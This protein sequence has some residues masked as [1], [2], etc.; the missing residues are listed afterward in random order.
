MPKEQIRKRGKRKP[1]TQEDEIPKKVVDQ[2]I[3]DEVRLEDGTIPQAVAPSAGPSGIHPARAALLAGRRAPPPH[4]AASSSAPAGDATAASDG[5]TAQPAWGRQ[6]GLD[7]DYPF[8][9]LN[10]DLKAYFRNVDDQIR[11]WEGV[12]SAGE[13]REDRSLFLASVLSELRSNELTVSTDPDTAVVLERMMPSLSD[14]GRR[15]IGDAF[16][17][18]WKQLVGHRFGSHVAQTWFTLAADTL[19]REVS[20]P[21]GNHNQHS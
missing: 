11:D 15:V 3:V 4:M 18:N 10:P 9:V 5:E 21:R 2:P 13:E 20:S 14:W 6:P 16:G 19:D 7:G 8:G 1:K 17:D 12:S